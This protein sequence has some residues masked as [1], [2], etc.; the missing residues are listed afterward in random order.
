[1]T[2]QD[3]WLL[4]LRVVALLCIAALVI[5]TVVQLDSAGVKAPLLAM[6]GSSFAILTLYPP[7]VITILGIFQDVISLAGA[8]IVIAAG[9]FWLIDAISN[10]SIDRLQMDLSL[11]YFQLLLS[12]IFIYIALSLIVLLVLA[13]WSPAIAAIK[14]IRR[15]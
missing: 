14:K 9:R 13:D 15:R 11:A 4:G 2:K 8:G 3:K 10:G 6:M 12:V 5:L 1:M 7:R